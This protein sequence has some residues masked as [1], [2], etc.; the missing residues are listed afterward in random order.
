MHVMQTVEP[1]ER[2]RESVEYV[3]SFR[4]QAIYALRILYLIFFFHGRRSAVRLLELF[5]ERLFSLGG[6]LEL[7]SVLAGN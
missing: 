2:E 7:R 4:L 5:R 1:R 6:Y 3:V